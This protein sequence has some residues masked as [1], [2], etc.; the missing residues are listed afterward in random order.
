MPR[1]S[2]LSRALVA[3]LAATALAAPSALARP[4]DDLPTKAV[5]PPVTDLRMPDTRDA[6]PAPLR[7]LRMPDTQ[8]AA[9]PPIQPDLRYK[10]GTSSLAGTKSPQPAQP[11][12]TDNDTPWAVIGLGLAGV[13]IAAGGAG[14][15]TVTRRRSRVA[16]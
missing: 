12:G 16:A 3:A 8:D 10:A 2:T 11:A 4:I 7:D 13:A 9:K 6:S 15:A 14:I 1:S 5:E